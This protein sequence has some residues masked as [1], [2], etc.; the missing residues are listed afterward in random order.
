MGGTANTSAD[1]RPSGSTVDPTTLWNNFLAR[2][3][4]RWNG[5]GATWGTFSTAFLQEADTYGVRDQ[6][7]ALV[8]A[9]AGREDGGV[10]YLAAYGLT[11]DQTNQPDLGQYGTTLYRI[12]GVHPKELTDSSKPGWGTNV[13]AALFPNSMDPTPQQVKNLL[14]SASQQ[15]SGAF[16]Y[17]FPLASVAPTNYQYMD[18][19]IVT[20]RQ[21]FPDWDEALKMVEV[22]CGDTPARDQI[23]VSVG[24]NWRSITNLIR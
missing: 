5:D 13:Y 24:G 10:K 3:P 17:R 23:E 9:A 6:A 4:V 20:L 21:A 15:S 7:Q 22:I 1:A 18:L 16:L 12:S 14:N 11:V 2:T 19:S 8:D